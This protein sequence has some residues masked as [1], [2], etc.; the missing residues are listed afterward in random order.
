MERC[1]PQLE[2]GQGA[3][4][5]RY[6]YRYFGTMSMQPKIVSSR[7]GWPTRV[8]RNAWSMVE[9][10]KLRQLAGL[11]VSLQELAKA[12]GRSSPQ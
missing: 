9:V 1:P 3:G 4:G 6:C 5:F 12:L 11:G 2:L 7:V 10:G 8:I